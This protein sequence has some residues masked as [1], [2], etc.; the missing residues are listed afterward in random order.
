MRKY[1]LAEIY[2]EFFQLL[3]E[4]IDYIQEG[5]NADRFRENFQKNSRIVVPKVYWALH[6]EKKFWLWNIFPELKLTIANL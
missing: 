6:H 3:Y 4:E 1:R 5:K 2:R